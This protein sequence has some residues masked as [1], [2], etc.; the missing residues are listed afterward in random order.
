MAINTNTLMGLVVY[1]QQSEGLRTGE[2][3]THTWSVLTYLLG[4]TEVRDYDGSWTE[5]RDLVR[6][7]IEKA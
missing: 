7:P 4:A 6:T 1:V 3:S 5:W 2:R